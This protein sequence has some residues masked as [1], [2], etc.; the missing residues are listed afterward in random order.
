MSPMN[1]KPLNKMIDIRG[2]NKPINADTLNTTIREVAGGRKT[3]TKK[4]SKLSTSA[5]MR[6]S[7]SPVLKLE[8]PA[9]AFG[10]MTV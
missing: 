9:G 6:L 3:R 1:N 2:E 7:R 5:I 10:S 8:M 4:F